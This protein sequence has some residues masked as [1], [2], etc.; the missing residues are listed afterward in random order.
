MVDVA[1]DRREFFVS[2]ERLARQDNPQQGQPD[3]EEDNERQER[4]PFHCGRLSRDRAK[5]LR[6]WTLMYTR[7]KRRDKSAVSHVPGLEV[8]IDACRHFP[9]LGDRPH[10]Q[11]SPSPHI[12]ACKHRGHARH[13]I[14]IDQNIA[15]RIICDA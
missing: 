3:Q 5:E 9:A 7:K 14:L 13:E 1:G 15:P 8:L 6:G 4:Y 2:A 11:R 10:N 12:A